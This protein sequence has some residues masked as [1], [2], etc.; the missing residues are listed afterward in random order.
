MDLGVTEKVKPLRD[1]VSEMVSNDI[2]PLDKEFHEE[3]GKHHSGSRW[4]LTDRQLEILSYL[5]DLAKKRGLWN[6][7]RLTRTCP[8][9][10]QR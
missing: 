7:Y 3:V 5:K 4:Q 1:K 10:T 9:E 2:E 8:R 6:F